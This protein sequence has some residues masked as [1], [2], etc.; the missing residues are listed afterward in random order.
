MS[1]RGCTWL[2]LLV[3]PVL[4]GLVAGLGG[5]V[6]AGAT[7]DGTPVARPQSSPSSS[8]S[9]S[10][11]PTASAA[12]AAY[13]RLSPEQRV[14]QLFVIGVTS[15]APTQ[16][17]VDR[18]RSG[19]GGNVFLRGRN[20]LGVQAQAAVDDRLRALTTHAGVRPFIAADQE[21][22]G[23][24]GLTGDG[25]E[26]MPSAVR[27][28]QQPPPEL[29][30]DATTWAMQLLD[31][32]VTLDLAPVADVVPADVGTSN[33]PIGSFYRQYGDNPASVGRSTAAF[34]RGMN[35]ASLA[36]T[37]KHFPGLGR[38]TGNTDSD[39]S[40]TDPTTRNDPYLAAYR[41]AVRA[42]VPFLMVSS[43]NYPAIDADNRACF[44]P[45]V[46]ATMIRKDLDFDGVIISDS[47]G[48][49]SLA[50]TPPGVRATRF[51]AAGGTMVL[52]TNWL[53][54]GRMST[55]VLTK[56]ASDEDFAAT[57]ERDVLLVLEAKVRAGLIG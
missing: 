16:E 30:A 39:P 51:L 15:D 32:G 31:A 8:S 40:A 41:P 19:A 53:D 3:V 44:S 26:E 43:A 10:A 9:P 5:Y 18:L 20:E 46:L 17:Q 29:R 48:S 56:A 21:G 49:A 50:S 12:T 1:A 23:A 52:D 7:G 34:V 25:F 42:G 47:F 54:L 55:A 28:G 35:D 36:S 27:Q 2:R 14:G 22:G 37:L 33:A 4:V 45:Y 6:V 24:Q 38:A 13:D 11:S 57:V